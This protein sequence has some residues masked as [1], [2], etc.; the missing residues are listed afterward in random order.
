MTDDLPFKV[1]RSNGTDC[2]E[3]ADYLLIARGE[4]H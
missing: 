1:V 2:L 3:R 4:I